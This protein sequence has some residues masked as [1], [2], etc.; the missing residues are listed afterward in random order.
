MAKADQGDD[1]QTA[2]VR[3]KSKAVS[4]PTKKVPTR[5]RQERLFEVKAVQAELDVALI[6]VQ[7]TNQTDNRS[8]YLRHRNGLAGSPL[9]A[10]SS[11]KDLP[12]QIAGVYFIYYSNPAHPDYAEWT[13][14]AESRPVYIGK[15]S[16]SIS[17]RLREHIASID[18]SDNLDLS[19]FSIRVIKFSDPD[20]ASHVENVFLTHCNAPWNKTG[21]GANKQGPNRSSQNLSPWDAL[22][23]GRLQTQH[24]GADADADS[25]SAQPADPALLERVEK[26]QSKISLFAIP[27]EDGN[28][29]Q[30]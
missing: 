21:F 15:S 30:R 28:P 10:L 20:E 19:D 24:V 29:L 18:Q 7:P 23:G 17:G 4:A 27:L 14:V 1:V 9:I 26:L 2:N 3:S 5:P 16:A 12:S 6:L 13:N 8:K 22:H 25:S 11:A